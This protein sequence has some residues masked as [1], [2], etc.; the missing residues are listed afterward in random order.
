MLA[1]RIKMSAAAAV[2]SMSIVSFEKI[3]K[4]GGFKF[5]VAN[6]SFLGSQLGSSCDPTGTQLGLNQDSGR[7]ESVICMMDSVRLVLVPTFNLE[8]RNGFQPV[9]SSFVE[10]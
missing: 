4:K 10:I 2:A 7:L 5:R 3:N 6:S 8:P 1:S 9:P